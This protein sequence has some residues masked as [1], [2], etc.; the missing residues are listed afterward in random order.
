MKQD[1][2]HL[3]LLSIFH[4]VV[5]ALAALTA[6]LPVIYLIVGLFIVF[7]ADKFPDHGQAPPAFLGGILV[8]FAL[9]LITF[10]WVFAAL[11]AMTGRFLVQHR[12]HTF[13]LVM[14]GIECIFMPFG[15]VLG[16]LTIVV[17]V[18]ESVKPLFEPQPPPP[19]VK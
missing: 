6:L 9:M 5:A 7:A 18:R 8:I 12:H 15:T 3:R 17:L 2:E 11:L 16:V 10:G 19:V 13:C 4:Y 14:A 1:E